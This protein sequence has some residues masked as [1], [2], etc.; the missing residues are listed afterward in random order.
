MWYHLSCLHCMFSFCFQ[1]FYDS[2]EAGYCLDEQLYN[3]LSQDR[4]TSTPV[5]A[6][7]NQ[8]LSSKSQQFLQ[9]IVGNW[10][11]YQI[12]LHLNAH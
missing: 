7:Q 11:L 12:F 4:P 10:F 1:W 3:V 9:K 2:I 6:N 8:R 5:K